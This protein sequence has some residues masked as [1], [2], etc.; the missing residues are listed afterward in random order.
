MKEINEKFDFNDILIMPDIKTDIN[1]RYNDVILQGNLP[2]FTAPMDSVVDLNNV[3]KFLNN[4]IN[5]TLPR[6]ISYDDF[7]DYIN[8]NSKIKKDLSGV[9][10]SFGLDEITTYYKNNFKDIHPNAKILID[11]ANGHMQKIVDVCR[12]IKR[13]RPDIKIM[14]GN[15]ANPKTYEWYVKNEC[16]DFIR[17]GIGNGNGCLTTKQ[18]GIG[19]PMASLIRE[20]RDVKNNYIYN[21]SDLKLPAIVA[22]GG[23][24]E[25]SDIIKALGMGADYVMIGS[26]FNKTLESCASSYLF[27]I[28]LNNKWAEY[29]FKKGLPVKKHFRGMSTKQAQKAMGK[30][31][32]KTSEGVTRY[33]KVEYKL[34]GWVENFEHYLRNMMS[35]T[36]AKTLDDFI[37]NCEF[38]KISKSSYERFNK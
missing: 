10:V 16:V 1:S 7:L 12:E 11:V 24:K 4:K 30:K 26:L 35:Y 8:K 6:T 13:L 20:M 33:R 25:Y 19:Y 23:M 2:L 5:V 38:N 9:F 27:G 32:F 28:K 37:G 36:N 15:I 17:V 22:D 31:I 34:S 14:V 3:H 18:S 21:N 29:F